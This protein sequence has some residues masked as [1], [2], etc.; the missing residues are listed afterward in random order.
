MFPRDSE[1]VR[2][3]G[4]SSERQMESRRRWLEGI[5]R[6]QSSQLSLPLGPILPTKELQLNS[7]NAR[8]A[9]FHSA[10]A[11]HSLA[12]RLLSARA[13]DLASGESFPFCL[14]LRTRTARRFL[15][16]LKCCTPLCSSSK[17]SGVGGSLGRW[18]LRGTSM[19][20]A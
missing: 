14:S 6:A 11:A 7:L 19:L 13:R 20:A 10:S 8:S 2:G 1:M 16:A 9:R 5:L 18:V 17:E 3:T 12:E 15:L 4:E